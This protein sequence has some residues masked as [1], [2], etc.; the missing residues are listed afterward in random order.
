MR[1]VCVFCFAMSNGD[2]PQYGFLASEFQIKWKFIQ[3]KL[4]LASIVVLCEVSGAHWDSPTIAVLD[5]P[6]TS[7]F[8]NC[9]IC[10]QVESC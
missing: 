2:G 1:L 4:S 10:L 3:Q 6:R 8:S 5:C 7:S 9:L